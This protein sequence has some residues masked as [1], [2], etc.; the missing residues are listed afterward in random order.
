M[1]LDSL[2]PIIGF[3]ANDFSVDAAAF[4]TAAGAPVPGVFSVGLVTTAP[5]SF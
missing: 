5:H 4:K 2:N 1:F 3:D